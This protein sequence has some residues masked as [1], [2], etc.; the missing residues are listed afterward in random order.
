MK[1]IQFDL[2]LE[3]TNLVLEALGQLPFARV[4]HL[5]GRLQDRA[6]QQLEVSGVAPGVN[7]A[8]SGGL[9]EQA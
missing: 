4:Y 7:G 5:I 9:R 6:R 8:S 2:T 3:E 1:S